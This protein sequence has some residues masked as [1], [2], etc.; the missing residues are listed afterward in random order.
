MRLA[1]CGAT[2]WHTSEGLDVQNAAWP[3]TFH[4][5][6]ARLD[7]RA[8]CESARVSTRCAARPGGGYVYSVRSG[9]GYFYVF[10]CH[11]V[12]LVECCSLRLVVVSSHGPAA[13]GPSYKT[14]LRCSHM[15]QLVYD[16]AT[17]AK[18]THPV[19]RCVAGWFQSSS[20]FVPTTNSA[21]AFLPSSA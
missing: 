20:V 8:D 1:P 4:E 17:A 9:A 11:G 3:E 13:C 12:S 15:A 10:V 16:G 14:H 2:S 18:V 7:I 6:I 21:Q 19:P 5:E